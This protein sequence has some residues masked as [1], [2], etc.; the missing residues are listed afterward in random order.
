MRTLC[1]LCALCA[2]R[3]I[4]WCGMVW[5]CVATLCGVHAWLDCAYAVRP[6]LRVCT[7][8]AL[9]ERRLVQ[10]HA[11]HRLDRVQ[12]QLRHIP[13]TRPIRAH[14][15]VHDRINARKLARVAHAPARACM[16]LRY[17]W[18]GIGDGRHRGGAVRLCSQ[19]RRGRRRWTGVPFVWHSIGKI[20]R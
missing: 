14:K 6:C 4:A 11:T 19:K 3:G 5:R 13:H 7:A 20:A 8:T 18:Y 9:G 16:H 10:L 17:Y 12:P 2:W 1:A 15:H